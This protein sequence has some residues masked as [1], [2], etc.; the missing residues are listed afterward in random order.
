M[1]DVRP[2]HAPHGVSRARKRVAN[3]IGVAATL[4]LFAIPAVLFAPGCQGHQCES[5][6]FHD[7]GSGPGEGE[8]ADKDQTVWETTP[9]NGPWLPFTPYRTWVFHPP[10]NG[11]PI[12]SIVTY[13]SADANPNS[14]G[15]NYTIAA[16]NQAT[17]NAGN[18]NAIFIS[19]ATCAPFYIRVVM[20]A[21]PG[22]TADAGPLDD[23]GSDDFDAGQDADLD[24]GDG[25]D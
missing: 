18:P 12:T 21:Y 25:G 24:A 2:L 11:L 22:E 1:P 6:G 23:S 10:F 15:Q 9:D 3:A 4:S 17:V 16:G 5:D 7:Y 14:A 13:I 20:T 19:N 8:F